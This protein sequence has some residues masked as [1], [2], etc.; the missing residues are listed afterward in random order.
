MKII[1]LTNVDFKEYTDNCTDKCRFW[2]CA[3][4]DFGCRMLVTKDYSLK[5]QTSTDLTNKYQRKGLAGLNPRS[6]LARL[7]RKNV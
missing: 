5:K 6:T 4:A 1:Q 2:V 3:D 7:R